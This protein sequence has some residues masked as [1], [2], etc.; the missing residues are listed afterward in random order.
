VLARLD[1]C[2]L[3]LEDIGGDLTRIEAMAGLCP[4]LVV[5]QGKAGATL[6]ARGE[7]THF[8]PPHVAQ[9]DPTGAGDI[10]AAAFFVHLQRTGDAQAAA[11]LATQVA[12]ISV[13]R[14]GLD[15]VP[16]RDEIFD[17]MAEAV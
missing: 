14:S 1:A 5:T 12:A 3:G 9:V 4:A 17:L 10:F 13:T 7:E 2:V 8:A 11:R 6:Y 15:G 16:T